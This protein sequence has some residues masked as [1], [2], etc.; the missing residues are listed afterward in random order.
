M[1]KD[2]GYETETVRQNKYILS[3]PTNAV[4][5]L[6]KHRKIQGLSD[7]DRWCFGNCSMTAP[8]KF[9]DVQVVKIGNQRSHKIDGAVAIIICYKIFQDYKAEFME[10]VG[11]A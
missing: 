6:L 1:L 5:D 8:D 9:G 7:V 10:Y 3:K 11:A 2:Y 4:E